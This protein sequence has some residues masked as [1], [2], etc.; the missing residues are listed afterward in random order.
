MI[1]PYQDVID[2]E[3]P[4]LEMLPINVSAGASLTIETLAAG[5]DLFLGTVMNINAVTTETPNVASV[6]TIDPYDPTIRNDFNTWCHL[7]NL[8][9]TFPR[10]MARRKRV[11]M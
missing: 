8:L 11:A 3:H 4:E 9:I 10:V 7:P 5:C 6:R 1:V 2:T